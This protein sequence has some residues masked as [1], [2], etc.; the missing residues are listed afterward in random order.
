MA[1]KSRPFPS[2]LQG[3]IA[4]WTV[5]VLKCSI[6]IIIY[7]SW[8]YCFNKFNTQKYSLASRLWLLILYWFSVS[9]IFDSGGRWTAYPI[10]SKQGQ[11]VGGRGFLFWRQLLH[12]QLS[13]IIRL[14]LYIRKEIFFKFGICLLFGVMIKKFTN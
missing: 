12:V 10:N 4:A 14:T 7:T 8:G 2:C 6:I 1:I 5:N 13:A 11:M 3:R 9:P